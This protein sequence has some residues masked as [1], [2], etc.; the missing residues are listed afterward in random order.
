MVETN[1]FNMPVHVEISI[2]DILNY[3]EGRQRPLKEGEEVFK[4][5]HIIL[6]GLDGNDSNLIQSLCLQT[7]GV[8][9]APHEIKISLNEP[10]TCVC[11]CKAG[12]SGYCKHIIATLIYIN[13]YVFSSYIS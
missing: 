10:W 3:V 12:L 7:S 4:A 5:G 8:T 11:S 13:R 9:E 1:R 6:C 2:V